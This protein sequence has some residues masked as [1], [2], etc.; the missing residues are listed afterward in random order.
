MINS[1]LRPLATALLVLCFSTVVSAAQLQLSIG[2]DVSYLPDFSEAP[3]S[4]ADCWPSVPPPVSPN[5]IHQF[6]LYAELIGATDAPEQSLNGLLADIVMSPGV[7]PYA[8]ISYAAVAPNPVF[9]PPPPGP[10]GGGARSL[11][12]TNADQ[13]AQDL[14]R[15]A[16]LTDQL[17]AHGFDPGESG[18]TLVGN[19]F[20]QWDI[21]ID[22]LATLYAAPAASAPVDPWA[23]WEGSDSVV[24][25]AQD[26]LSSNVIRMWNY[27]PEPSSF[28]LF[29][30]AMLGM[31]G[32]LPRR[33]G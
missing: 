18:P 7:N 8:G 21:G 9:D 30:L 2:Y 26:F 17:A 28:V 23:I 33:K 14:V 3:Y 19:F 32:M 15:I 25:P 20:V 27:C 16:V 10:L 29:G 31:T 5:D 11:Y 22:P 12:T 1:V 4:L 24:P 6:S 13:G